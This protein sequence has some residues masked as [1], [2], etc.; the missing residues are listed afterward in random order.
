MRGAAIRARPAPKLDPVHVL[1]ASAQAKRFEREP[2]EARAFFFVFKV[3]GGAAPRARHAN[4]ESAERERKRLAGLDPAG[5]Y[6]T[7]RATAIAGLTK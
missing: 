1:P 7:Y 4:A 3:N 2:I 6:V 5:L